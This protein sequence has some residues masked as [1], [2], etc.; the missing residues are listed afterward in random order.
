M[1]VG[2]LT[3]SMELYALTGLVAI[4][5]LYLFRDFLFTSK[6]QSKEPDVKQKPKPTRDILEKIRLTNSKLIIFYGSQTGTAEDYANRIAKEGRQRFGLGCLVADIEAY[7]MEKLDAFP[8]DCLAIFIMATYGE[9]EPTDNANDFFH[10][11]VGQEEVAFSKVSATAHD[12]PL[13]SLRYAMFGLGNRTYEHFNAVAKKLDATLT[14]FGARRIGELGLGDDDASLED[15]FIAW[16]EPAWRVICDATGTAYVGAGKRT[17]VSNLK[18][19]EHEGGLVDADQLHLGE[20]H[21]KASNPMG[22]RP[23][24][25]AKFPY[26]APAKLTR[27]LFMGGDRNCIHLEIDIAG[28]G[29]QYETGDHIGLWAVNPEEEVQRFAEA[30]GLKERLD[31]VVSI[32][33]LDTSQTKKP[34]PTPTTY[35][36][37]LRFYVDICSA[38]SR[39]FLG[40]LINY[41]R[42]PPALEFITE[43]ANDPEKYASEIIAHRLTLGELYLNIQEIEKG[44]PEK[45]EIPFNLAIESLGRLLPRYY[46]ISSSSRMHPNSVHVTASV[47]TF[48]PPAKPERVVKGLF[49]NFLLSA[50]QLLMD[51]KLMD[52]SPLSRTH[53][54]PMYIRKSNFRLP[55][56]PQVPVI[57]VGPGTGVAPFR[58]FIQERAMQAASGLEVSPTVLFFGC[59]RREE[60]FLYREEW[61]EL[62]AKVPDSSMHTAFSRETERKVYVQDLIRQERERVWPLVDIQKGSIYVCGDAKH[63]AKDVHQCFIEMAREQG[64]LGGGRQRLRQEAPGPVPVPGGCLGLVRLRAW[65]INL[66]LF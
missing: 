57:M 29:I 39:Q 66:S 65:P 49:T 48:S 2:T 33:S 44:S 60:D 25:D 43:L 1:A 41:A 51:P 18:L 17:A 20:L 14:H 54:I 64:P 61:D 45:T 35:G 11:I 21:D 24:Y 42:S 62:L 6:P 15:D 56:S 19:V 23:T 10:M 46:S 13:A 63:M 50:H 27:E 30:F 28:S 7:D 22:G 26:V 53:S 31:T 9:G 58:G 3:L 12:K 59:R 38:P 47:L 52:A 4:C 32:E 40:D 5:G 16:K 8:I 36:S 55:K 37:L 34:F